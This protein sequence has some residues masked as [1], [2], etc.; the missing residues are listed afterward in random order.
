MSY[1]SDR[2]ELTQCST[3]MTGLSS[4]ISIAQTAHANPT[5]IV[6]GSESAARRKRFHHDIVHI[7]QRFSKHNEAAANLL[8]SSTMCPAFS[9]S[10]G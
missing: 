4:R 10:T 7:L 9:K 6:D 1:S 8:T 5:C 2:R 3:R